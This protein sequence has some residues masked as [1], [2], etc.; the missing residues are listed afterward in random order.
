MLSRDFKLCVNIDSS[1]SFAVNFMHFKYIIFQFIYHFCYL[2]RSIDR[3]YAPTKLFSFRLHTCRCQITYSVCIEKQE[4]FAVEL[5]WYWMNWNVILWS[6][7]PNPIQSFTTPALWKRMYVQYYNIRFQVTSDRSIKEIFQ[8]T[9]SSWNYLLTQDTSK[10]LLEGS[11]S[12]KKGGN[13]WCW[14]GFRSAID[15]IDTWT[16]LLYIY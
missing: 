4:C 2:G 10:S 8:R 5:S 15:L 6:S 3:S 14:N 16:V 9:A 7:F 13:C 11:I 12:I 1:A